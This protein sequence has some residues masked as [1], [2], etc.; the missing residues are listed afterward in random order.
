MSASHPGQA[1]LQVGAAVVEISPPAGTPMAGFAARTEPSTGVHDPL[2]VR[3]LAVDDTCW[4]TVDV[5][6]LHED[7]C[8]RIADGLPL[9]P[10]RVAI[11]ATHT[12][13]GPCVMPGR[14]GGHDPR[15]LEE[16]VLTCREAAK[17]AIASQRPATLQYG[18]SRGVD[19]ARNRRHPERAV[20]PPVQVA[21]FSDA[22]GQVLAWIVLYPCHPVVL[23]P[24]NRLISGDY[25]TF[26][27]RVLE[28]RSPGSV[29]LFLPGAAGDINSGHPADASYSLSGS[30]SRT[31]EQART[32]GE[33][34]AASVLGTRLLPISAH[35]KT[36]AARRTV[37]VAMD[38]RDA[39]SPAELSRQWEA[40][41]VSADPG[42]RS[43]LNAWKQWAMDRRPEEDMSW[44]APVSVF[45]WQGLTLV[46]LPGEPFLATSEAI[47]SQVKGPVFVTGYTNGC[48]GYFPTADEYDF[49][50]YEVEDAH[51]Y[52]GMPAPFA[53]GS[54]EA[55]IQAALELVGGLQ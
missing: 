24:E 39:V 20:D 15:L 21:T 10:E 25:P 32:I 28:E 50:G 26:T 44:Q 9:M 48:P 2:S 16:I 30:A 55:L 11:T 38:S 7:T 36:S 42:R 46:G 5:C 40:E 12:H 1:A 4:I 35:G 29:A 54:A 18:Q 33:H 23:G 8:T 37:S 51:R 52:Y 3:A 43:L 31:M 17:A 6:G 53:P 34:V 14:L 19:V 49:G 27:R 45:T 13:A 41:A 47:A 22:S